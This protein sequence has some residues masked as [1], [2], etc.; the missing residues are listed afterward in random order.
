MRQDA[1]TGRRA[2]PRLEAHRRHDRDRA[3]ARGAGSARWSTASSRAVRRR[4]RRRPRGATGA[5]ELGL[6]Y[7]ADPAITRHLAAFLGAHRQALEARR[8]PACSAR[9]KS[10]LHPTAVLFNGGVF[11]AA[12]LRERMVEVLDAWLTGRGRRTAAGAARRRPRPRGRARR[13]LLRPGAARQGRAHPRRHGARVLRRHRDVD[14][15]GAGRARR[16]SRRCAWRRSAWRRAPRPTCRRRSSAWWSASR[17]S[18]ASSPPP[19]GATT[20]SGTWSRTGRRARGAAAGRGDAAGRRPAQPGEVVPV[21]LRAHVTEV[22]TLELWCVGE[23]GRRWKLE[24]NVREEPVRDRR[25][26]RRARGAAGMRRGPARGDRLPCAPCTCDARRRTRACRGRGHGDER[27]PRATSSAS[28]SA[29]PT[30]RSPTSTPP[31]ESAAPSRPGRSRSS[32]RRARWRRGRRCRRR[33]IWPAST[34]CRPGAPAT[35]V[36]RPSGA[37]GARAESRGRRVRARA[38]RARAGPAGHLG[39]VLAVPPAASIARAPILPWGAPEDVAAISPVEASARVPAPPRDVWDAALPE[40][41]A[42][43][44]GGGADACRRRSTRW[45]AS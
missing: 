1:S 45:R 12:P 2:G 37:G 24:Y 3:D 11:K 22:G 23:A 31:T 27:R 36:G 18:S 17:R 30:R 38:G 7:A 29:R 33:S 41:A 16:R 21:R 34:S 9:G 6:P 10:F 39:Q 15:G 28:I 35:A 40:R 42:R 43:R 4:A 8:P 14:A 19:C 26:R 25:R 5:H 20:R 44:A 13:R 32:S